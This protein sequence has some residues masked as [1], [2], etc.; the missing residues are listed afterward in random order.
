M[1]FKALIIALGVLFTVQAVT[2]A[3]GQGQRDTVNRYRV[4]AQK[5]GDREVVS[6][7]NEVRIVSPTRLFLPNAF[8]PNGD[9][10]N[11]TFGPVT[12]GI[13]S[14]SMVIHNRW[15]E[16]VFESDDPEVRWDG[17]YEGEQVVAGNTFVY[18]ISATSMDH[19]RLSK[20][21]HVT[22]VK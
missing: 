4:V 16:K 5:A 18:K 11:D 21:G 13:K 2:P 8:T 6:T 10:L 7:S 14:Y 15:G 20:K 19:E 22:V 1:S 17:T 9:G 12:R 3:I